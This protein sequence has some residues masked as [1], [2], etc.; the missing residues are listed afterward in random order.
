MTFQKAHF[1]TFSVQGHSCEI[2]TALRVDF[3][4]VIFFTVVDQHKNNAAFSFNYT[5]IFLLL[6]CISFS[7]M[8]IHQKIWERNKAYKPAN[9]RE[10]KFFLC[11]TDQQTCHESIVLFVLDY[12]K[13]ITFFQYWK[14]YHKNKSNAYSTFPKGKF[15]RRVSL[16]VCINKWNKIITL[17]LL[18]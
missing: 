13:E 3:P 8:T 12:K 10:I 1:T 6:Q 16:K 2:K 15:F 11:I 5:L 14:T 7:K 18:L 4:S 17:K 9:Y